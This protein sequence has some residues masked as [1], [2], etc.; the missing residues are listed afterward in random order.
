MTYVSALAWVSRG[1]AKA[2]PKQVEMTEEEI[3][4]MKDIPVVKKKYPSS[5]V[6]SIAVSNSST[7]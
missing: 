7:T 1:F 2:V 3:N 4:A 6:A 5:Y